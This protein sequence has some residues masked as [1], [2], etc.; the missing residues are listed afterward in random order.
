MVIRSMLNTVILFDLVSL[1]TVKESQDSYFF[2]FS[3]PFSWGNKYQND[4]TIYRYLLSEK[5]V[6]KMKCKRASP[7][8]LKYY[9]VGKRWRGWRS[10][11]KDLQ[12]FTVDVES[13]LKLILR[14]LCLF[15]RHQAIIT[16]DCW[17]SPNIAR[18][19][20]D[21]EKYSIK[22]STFQRITQHAKNIMHNNKIRSKTFYFMF[23]LWRR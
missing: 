23:I 11:L 3:I 18:W 13:Y 14:L 12:V 8:W 15:N 2:S 1:F 22:Y 16:D 6:S 21:T 4:T 17:V 19:S 5:V 10:R 20:S 7:S 9:Q